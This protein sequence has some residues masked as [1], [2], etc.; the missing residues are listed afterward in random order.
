MLVRWYPFG[1]IRRRGDV[2]N[3]LSGIQQE[4]NRLFD[5]FFGERRQ[6][7]AEGTWLPSVDVSETG[8]E[9]VVRAELPGLSKDDVELNLQDNVLTLKGEKKQ[10]N[11]EEKE[12]YHR[13]E[14]SYG[15]F[16]R[17]F[18]LPAGV[19]PENVQASFKDGVL[20]IALPK[21][22]EAKQKKIEIATGS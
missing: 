22:E 10:E 7:L 1:S 13:V 8:E 19:D 20:V 17:S 14:R 15:S 9:I 5:E 6:E 12:D 2:F 3:D 4:M 11:K 18:T 21:V 16:S